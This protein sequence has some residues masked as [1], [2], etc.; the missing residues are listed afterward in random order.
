MELEKHKD[1]WAKI[2]SKI[3]IDSN[4]GQDKIT[5]YGSYLS[6]FSMFSPDIKEIWDVASLGSTWLTPKAFL[7]AKPR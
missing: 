4:L 1:K 5:N 7:L 2:K 6:S 3:K